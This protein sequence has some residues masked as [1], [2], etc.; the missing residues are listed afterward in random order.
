MAESTP[1]NHLYPFA[2]KLAETMLR[3]KIE[4]PEPPAAGCAVS[5]QSVQT[6]V[7]G[8]EDLRNGWTQKD[9]EAILDRPHITEPYRQ[10]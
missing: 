6:M 8:R 4:A 7:R 2:R 9:H 10:C 1:M 3:V 5:L